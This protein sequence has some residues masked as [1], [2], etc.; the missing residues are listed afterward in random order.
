[1]ITELA[2]WNEVRTG[3]GLPAIDMGIGLNTA[4]I[5]SGNIGSPKRMDYTVIGDGVN[6]AARLESACKQY[7]AKILISENTFERL[8]GTYRIRAVDR[9]VVKGRREPVGIFEVL[10]FH[11]ETTF[12]NM[13]KALRGYEDGLTLY[14]Q[15]RFAEAIDAFRAVIALNDRDRL[16]HLYIERCR[17]LIAD[18]PGDDWNGVWVLTE[19]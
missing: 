8:R 6:L 11:T 14:R 10:D 7:H 9:V 19:K 15:G 2:A 3:N 5:V 18:S 12:P 17:R 4:E 1:M 16:P 13:S